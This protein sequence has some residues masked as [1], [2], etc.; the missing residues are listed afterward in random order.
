MAVPSLPV[1]F[2]QIPCFNEAGTLAETVRDIPRTI[3]GVARVEL[4]V[5]DD[6]ST[7]DTVAVAHECGVDHVVSHASNR[8]LAAAYLTGLDACVRL[9]AD[10]VVNTDA[11]NQYCGA[12]VATIVAPVVAHKADVVIGSRPIDSIESFSKAKRR[13]QRVGTATV[14]YLSKAG[15][16]DATSGFRALTRDAALRLQVFG[17]Y[18]YTLETLMQAGSEGLMVI[19]VPVGVNPPTRPSRLVKSSASYVRRSIPTIVRSFA[20]Y[21][22][23]RFFAAVGAVPFVAGVVLVVRWVLLKYLS[24]D[25]HSRVPSLVGAAVCFLAATQIWVLAFVA[26]LMSANRRVLAEIRLA[27]RREE[28]ERFVAPEPSP[29]QPS[30]R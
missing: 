9:G 10:I 26:D 3:P 13:L 8:G 15:V 11:D 20:L 27:Q 1:V 4:L 14:R 19:S 21:R 6:G 29:D 5:I 17:R 7:D 16:D 12:D 18:T 23:F 25:V 2:V 28:M 30:D 22:P 24:D